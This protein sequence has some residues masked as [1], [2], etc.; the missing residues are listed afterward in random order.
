M[1]ANGFREEELV[2][3]RVKVGNE[4]QTRTFPI[5]AG[6]LRLAHKENQSLNLQTELINWD[7]QYAAP[8]PAKVSS[9]DM[10]PPTAKGM[11]V[12]QKA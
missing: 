12:C 10:A 5:V 4:W 9:S 3:R 2:S 8:L 11:R 1:I 6:R 7:G